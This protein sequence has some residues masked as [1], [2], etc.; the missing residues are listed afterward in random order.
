MV[1]HANSFFYFGGYGNDGKSVIA[2]FD[3][4][5]RQWSNIGNLVT[6]R[7]DHGAIFDGSFFL[8]AG[9]ISRSYKT[10]R[11]NFA[12]STMICE[13]QLPEL[14]NYQEYPELLLVEEDY[15]KNTWNC[16]IEKGQIKFKNL[17]YFPFPISTERRFE[18]KKIA[19]L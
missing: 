19:R 4:A 18:E 12:G 2:K 5:T 11:C 14:T 6:G 10:E 13:E 17:P 8:V 15:C 3:S 1:H 7:Q 16:N 9:G